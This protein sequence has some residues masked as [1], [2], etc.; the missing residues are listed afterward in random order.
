MTSS[1]LILAATAGAV[2][3]ALCATL[4]AMSQRRRFEDH[5]TRLKTRARALET[6]LMD[7]QGAA[8]AFET[9][10]VVLHDDGVDLVSGEDALAACAGILDVAAD[11]QAVVAALTEADPSH[12][13]KLK[14][15][16]ER[17]EACTFEARGAR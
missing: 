5:L 11:A 13:H 14:A 2:C 10:V 7:S 3:L 9:A 12:A 17:G 6:R 16:F 4:W 8:E 1:D 15:L